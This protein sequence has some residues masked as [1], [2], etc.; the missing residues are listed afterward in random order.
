MAGYARGEGGKAPG[1]FGIRNNDAGRS[2]SRH[3]CVSWATG[4]LLS[5]E[6][7][8]SSVA[9]LCAELFLDPDK[10]VVLRE[11]VRARQ[12]AGLDL[13]AIRGD[14]QVGNGGILGLAGAV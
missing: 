3:R 1:K 12:R 5:P 6:D 8:L 2:I 11:P 4:C 9:G 7:A 14:G 10:L 13:A